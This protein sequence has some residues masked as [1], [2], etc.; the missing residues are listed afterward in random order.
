MDR[1]SK[2]LRDNIKNILPYSSARDE[3]VIDESRKDSLVL[4]DANENSLGSIL[5]DGLNRYPDPHQRQL[6]AELGG[7]MSVSPEF[8]FLSNGSDEAIDYLI[9]IFCNPGEDELIIMPPTFPMY[10]VSA[11]INS[12]KTIE[13]ALD[14]DFQ[15]RLDAVKEA[16][17]LKSK[18]LF[19][20]SPNNPTGNLMKRETIV[21]LIKDFPGYVVVDEAYIDFCPD[22]SVLPLINEFDNLIILRTFSKAWGLAGIRLGVTIAQ[23]EVIEVLNKIK[24]PYNINLLTERAARKALRL[25]KQKR[26]FSEILIA[27]RERLKG[28]LE[29]SRLVQ[30]IYPS[31][32]NFL[33]VRFSDASAVYEKLKDKGIIVRFQGSVP[34]LNNCLRITIGKKEDN[35]KLFKVISEGL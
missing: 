24:P 8:M 14:E 5:G 33:L 21:S 11:R 25:E 22:E 20:C 26:K 15:I 16:F 28:L 9:R 18:L 12:V 2:Y 34:G 27:E 10:K 4:L 30:N 17:S 35:D 6:K 13:V 29:S 19:I 1:L 3:F 7:V 32:S 23:K 31:N